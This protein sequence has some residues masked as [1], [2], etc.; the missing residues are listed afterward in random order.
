LTA[1][2]THREPRRPRFLHA[3]NA[4][5]DANGALLEL[6]IVGLHIDHHAVANSLSDVSKGRED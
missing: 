2:S 5:D 4:H 6:E 3:S 1:P